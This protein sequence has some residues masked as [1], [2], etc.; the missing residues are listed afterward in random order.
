[1][2]STLGAYGG[3]IAHG[4]LLLGAGGVLVTLALVGLALARDWRATS[5]PLLL[6]LVPLGLVLSLALRAG[7]FEVRYLILGMPGLVTLAGLGIVRLTR[8]PA[9]AAASV[10]L[11]MVPAGL[12]ISQQ[13]FDPSLARDDYRGAVATIERDARP[14]DAVVLSAPNQVEIF[15]YYYRGSLDTFP[16]PAQRPIDVDD[17]RNR[18]EDIRT[19]HQRVWL[20]SWA[21][22]EADP[23]G[24]I[25]NWLADNG[26]KATHEWYGSLQLSLIGFADAAAPTQRLD[27]AMDN[28]IVLEGYR[29]GS[30]ASRPGETLAL[31]LLWR[32]EQPVA[33]R[34]KVFTHLLNGESSVVAQRDAE[35][36]DNLR[37]TP[38]WQVGEE[39]E[40]N[41]GILVPAD[42]PHGTY[43]LEIGMYA[44]EQRARFS[45][46][47]D[48]LELGSISV[49]P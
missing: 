2:Q 27:V 35:P 8:V 20:V 45:G 23:K 26:F 43:T 11:L 4:D 33:G 24:F 28:G 14:S 47:G 12:A 9:L 39:I 16:L 37:P 30:H 19:H 13:Y 10:G 48:H 21:M 6:W 22:N 40:D 34:W 41:Y 49:T 42:L 1:V 25:A 5:L 17:T 31:T 46:F 44:G 32:A 36:G 3:G 15:T 7:L 18:L 29:L 38:T